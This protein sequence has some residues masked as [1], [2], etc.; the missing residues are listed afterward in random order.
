MF[1]S[2]LIQKAAW[3]AIAAALFAVVAAAQEPVDPSKPK[4]AARGIP[5]VD[6]SNNPQQDNSANT[7]QPDETP[8]TGAQIAGL[9]SP[10][11]G[12]SYWVPGLQYATT[13]QSQP[14]GQNNSTDWYAD[15][16]FGGNVTLLKN[17][18]RS[19]LALNE[20]A[21][22]FLSGATG[23]QSGWYNQLALQQS[24]QWG[25]WHLQ[26]LDQFSY[27]PESQMGFGGGTG[28]SLPGIGGSL[29]AYLP[30]LGG[31]L[32]PNQSIYSALGPR[33]S[34]AFATQMTYDLSRRS[35]VT[36]TGSY[37]ILR[38]TQ[39]GNVDSDI[40]GGSLGYNYTLSPKDTIGVVYRYSAYHF[41]GQ[42]QAFGEQVASLAYGRKITQ[43]LALQLYCGPDFTTYRI[44]ANGQSFRTSVYSNAN[45]VYGFERGSISANYFHGFADG[46]GVLVGSNIDEL[47][48]AVNRQL[49]RQWTGFLNFG[50]S[51]N[52][53]V[54]SSA[55]PSGANYHSWLGGGGLSRALGRNFSFSVTYTG[56]VLQSTI[57]GCTGTGCSSSPNQ[58]MAAVSLQWHTSPLVL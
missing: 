40:P 49:S 58:Q 34:N 27:L 37:G 4:P 41:Q 9:G 3:F 24:F 20:S 54:Q 55:T 10:E 12:H 14:L 31:G 29:G 35:S 19:Q 52:T 22:D 25:R 16:Y 42:P 39:S 15:H 32:V 33:Y 13:I 36:V 43:R 53:P 47:W 30:G 51:L 21:G 11:S 56:R 5:S 48:S 57:P 28:I 45:L 17:W 23:Q 2:K 50:F 18:G 38:F 46:S 26:F 7:V 1:A 8:L 6:N 44:A